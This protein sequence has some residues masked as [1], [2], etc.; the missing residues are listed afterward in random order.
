[1]SKKLMKSGGSLFV[2]VPNEIIEQWNLSKGDEVNLTVVD[3]AIRI[4]PKQ[5]TRMENISEEMVETYSKVMKGIQAKI[6]LDTEKN[7][8]HLEFSGEN[9]EAVKLL[10]HNLWSNLPALFSMLGVGSIEESAK[11]PRKKAGA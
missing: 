6:T 10:L 7:A 8:L 2:G 1:V 4:E 3:G 9:K 5:P 11:K